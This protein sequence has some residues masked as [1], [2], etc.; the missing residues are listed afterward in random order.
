MSDHHAAPLWK[1]LVLS[2]DHTKPL[3][4]SLDECIELLDFDADLIATAAVADLDEI[5]AILK[6]HLALCQDHRA[7]LQA[8]LEQIDQALHSLQGRHH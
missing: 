8:W 3:H 5:D 6:G 7:E 1:L 4:L 2:Q